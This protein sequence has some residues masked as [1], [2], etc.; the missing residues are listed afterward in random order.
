MLINLYLVTI[1]HYKLLRRF[2]I[3]NKKKDGEC[4]NPWNK[5]MYQETFPYN[6]Y[7]IGGTIPC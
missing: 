4:H 1:I 2:T 3:W 6:E 5:A 7:F